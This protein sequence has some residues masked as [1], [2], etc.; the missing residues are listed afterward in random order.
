M[1]K[2]LSSEV[3]Q[4]LYQSVVPIAKEVRKTFIA[5]DKVIEDSFGLIEQLGFLLLRFPAFE[6]TN[7]LSGFYIK[8]G[9]IKCI[10]INSAISLGRQ[11][12]SVWHEFYHSHTG[13]GTGISYTERLDQDES[14]F[15]AN[16]FAGCILMPENIVRE[17][18][19]S[20]NITMPY[21]KN[22]QLIE[23][24]TYFKVSLSALITR[25]GMIFPIYKSNLANRYSLTQNTDTAKRKLHQLVDEAHGDMTL[26]QPTND[27]YIPN[28]FFD[29]IEY[30]VKNERISLER[31]QNLLQVV[32]ELRETC[33]EK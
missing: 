19:D 4:E 1:G 18:L 29:D 15:R 5:E 31:A 33:S 20:K 28:S 11:Y 13:D 17:Y 16:A 6:G 32:D 9:T 30:N 8:K 24:Q 23:M 3:R 25:L 2:K 12:H 22:T 26:L 14:E 21:I 10:Y 7:E 27:I